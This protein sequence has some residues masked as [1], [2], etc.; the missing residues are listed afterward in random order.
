M[1]KFFRNPC[2]VRTISENRRIFSRENGDKTC[3]GSAETS[4]SIQMEF[5]VRRVMK[6]SNDHP[7]LDAILDTESLERQFRQSFNT[8]ALRDRSHATSFCTLHRTAFCYDP[9]RSYENNNSLQICMLHSN[10]RFC[11]AFSNFQIKVMA[12]LCCS[13][14]KI[15]STTTSTPSTTFNS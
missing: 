12:C 10:C 9:S 2:E 11:K 4:C 6:H 1:C 8:T 3:S 7:R 5:Q 15:A 14:G 13:H